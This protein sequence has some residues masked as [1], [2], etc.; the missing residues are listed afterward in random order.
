[1]FSRLKNRSGVI[2]AVIIPIFAEV[3][4]IE[5]RIVAIIV[6]VVIGRIE[7]SGPRIVVGPISG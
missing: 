6:V 5:V 7:Q 4:G 1:L 3:I 2:A